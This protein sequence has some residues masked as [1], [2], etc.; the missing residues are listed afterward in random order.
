MSIFSDAWGILKG[1]GQSVADLAARVYHA[2]A[3]A[4]HFILHLTDLVAGAWDWMIAGADALGAHLIGWA[5]QAYHTIRWLL[6]QALPDAARWALS[7]AV[8]WAKAAVLVV[9]KAWRATVGKVARAIR[10]EIAKVVSWARGI[11]AKIL[12]TLSGVYRWVMAAGRQIEGLVLHP[13]RLVTWIMPALVLPLVKWLVRKSAPI[14]VY[15]VKASQSV[16]SEVAHSIEDAL[17]K[18]L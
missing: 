8:G 4:V 2:I 17:A 14:I 16:M 7:K 1:A 5:D 18:I 15:L 13:D 6:I 12:R 3:G 10:S 9:D 11:V